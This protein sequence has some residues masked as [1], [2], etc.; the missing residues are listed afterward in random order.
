MVEEKEE[1]VVQESGWGWGR[2]WS[3]ATAAVKT[4]E[5]V[6]K[7]VQASEEGKKWVDQ[8]R[9]N[10]DVLRGLG[11]EVPFSL[12]IW[13]VEGLIYGKLGM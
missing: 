4:A 7:E 11:M 3:T 6:V 5:A 10:A 1:E 2:V 8:V 13:G 9:G 12:E